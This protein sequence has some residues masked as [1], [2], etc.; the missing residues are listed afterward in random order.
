MPENMAKL[1]KSILVNKSIENKMG[2]ENRSII[3]RNFNLGT[4]VK[5]YEKIM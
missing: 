2:K 3:V 5:K 4:M 1:A